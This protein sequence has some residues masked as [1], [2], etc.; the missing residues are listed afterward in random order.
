[1]KILSKI[2]DLKKDIF[3]ILLPTV[4]GIVLCAACLAGT[5]YAWFTASSTASSQ[6]ITTAEYSAEVTVAADGERLPEIGGVYSL[7]AGKTYTVTL[8]ATGNA[9]TG[10]CV[11]TLGGESFH[12]VAFP[13]E[14]LTDGI[15]TLFLVINEDTTLTVTPQWGLSSKLPAERWD[16]NHEYIYK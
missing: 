11:V 15:L 14:A 16:N 8:A 5:S 1:M 7:A 12:T 4:L 6:T 2:N 13:S 9:S 10:Y 3:F